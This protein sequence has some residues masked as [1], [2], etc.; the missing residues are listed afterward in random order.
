V[1]DA[2]RSFGWLGAIGRGV[3]VL[4]VGV[5]LLV[6]GPQTILTRLT[7]LDRSGRVAI[8]TAWFT[9]WIVVLAFGLRRLQER[10][11]V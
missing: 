1:S 10:R 3:L 8:A 11:L 7:G 6:I 2:E 9:V 4:G 5:G